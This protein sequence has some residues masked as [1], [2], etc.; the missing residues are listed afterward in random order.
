V[1]MTIGIW[2]SGMRGRCKISTVESRLWEALIVLR[3]ARLWFLTTMSKT[4]GRGHDDETGCLGF[5]E[6]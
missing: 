3:R 4:R 2:S 5:E 6:P 1:V